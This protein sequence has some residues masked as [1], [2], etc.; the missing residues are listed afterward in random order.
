MHDNL[1]IFYYICIN[2][3]MKYYE[4]KTDDGVHALLLDVQL[5]GTSGMA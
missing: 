1:S 5:K 3:Y 2:Q 4:K